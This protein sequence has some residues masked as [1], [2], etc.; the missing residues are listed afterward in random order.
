VRVAISNGILSAD[1]APGMVRWIRA[2]G[3]AGR[4]GQALIQHA[5]AGFCDA[6]HAHPL[7]PSRERE[8]EH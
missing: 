1:H 4:M 5:D 8:G 3:L 7:T 6:L 2:N